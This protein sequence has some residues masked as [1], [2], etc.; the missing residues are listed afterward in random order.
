MLFYLFAAALVIV[1]LV[2]LLPPLLRGRKTTPDA[3][4]QR[5]ANLTVLRGQM[6]ELEQERSEGLLAEADFEQAKRELQ[7]RLLEEVGPA[8][9]PVAGQND[10]L[11]SRPTAI[12][13]LVLLPVLAALGYWT[14]GTPKALD[15]L[16]TTRANDI[17]PEQI[18]QMVAK[19]AAR[20]EANPDDIQGWA[21][22]AKSYKALGRAQDA[23]NVYGRIEARIGD[24]PAL[25]VDYADALA[26]L[27]GGNLAGKPLALV[28]QALQLD[29]QNL[30][31]LWLAGTA[32]FDKKDFTKAIAYWERALSVLPPDAPDRQVLSEG[33]AEAKR[34]AGSKAE[35]KADP[36]RAVGGRV[37]LAPALKEQAAADDTVFIFARP[38]EGS[39]FPLAV[40]KLRVADLPYDFVL[41]DSMAMMAEQQLSSQKQVIVEARISRAGNA[42]AKAGDLQSKPVTASVGERKLKLRIDQ[43]VGNP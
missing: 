34:Q 13:L 26:M 7:R 12:A 10:K 6:A 27:A 8:A 33:I 36:R 43:V 15:P 19:L 31:A 37:E 32:A 3:D 21:M 16:A 38:L 22:L 18:D 17:T 9:A 40:A 39:R 24:N 35:S 20:L 11:R 2:L 4:R 29:P 14:L 28:E 5:A 30:F 1:T 25:L 23:A 42:I 41:D